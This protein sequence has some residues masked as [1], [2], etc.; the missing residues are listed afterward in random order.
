L[1]HRLP[2]RHVQGIAYIPDEKTWS[3]DF[4]YDIYMASKAYIRDE[5][6][7]TRDFYYGM[8]MA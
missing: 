5:K 8:Y 4:P 1:V 2:I 3:R 6:S 7:W